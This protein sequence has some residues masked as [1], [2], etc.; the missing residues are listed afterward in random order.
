MQG[1]ADPK[2]GLCSDQNISRGLVGKNSK[3]DVH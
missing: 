3:D 2:Q 1:K